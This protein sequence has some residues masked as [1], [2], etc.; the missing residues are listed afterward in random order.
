MLMFS[1]TGLHP[2]YDGALPSLA[3]V[4][5]AKLCLRRDNNGLH[6]SQGI[7]DCILTEYHEMGS[8]M[9]LILAQMLGDCMK[10]YLQASVRRFKYCSIFE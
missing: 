1:R 6:R 2:S 5:A 8:P 7:A 3:S 9:A 4:N 10:A